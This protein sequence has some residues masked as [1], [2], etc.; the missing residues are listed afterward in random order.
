MRYAGRHT[1]MRLIWLGLAALVVVPVSRA[2]MSA[3]PDAPAPAVPKLSLTLPAA[4]YEAP[5]IEPKTLICEAPPE[6]VYVPENR[7]VPEGLHGLM[8][9]YARNMSGRVYANWDVRYRKSV[10]LAFD[11][12]RLAE[13]RVAVNPDGTLLE[14]EISKTSGDKQDDLNALY[15]VRETAPFDPLPPGIRH[16]MVLCLRF[17]YRTY[18]DEMWRASDTD[19]VNRV[20]KTDGAR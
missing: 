8:R 1:F 3:I 11:K 7:R 18:D 2:Q 5:K 19:F 15:A 14:P 9:E 4:K 6:G 13:I 12:H 17:G 20:K 10:Q 16:P